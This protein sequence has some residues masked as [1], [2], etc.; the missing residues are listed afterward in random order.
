MTNAPGKQ[1]NTAAKIVLAAIL[2]G[3]VAMLVT[4]GIYRTSNP[5]LTKFVQ[6]RN[7]GSGEAKTDNSAHIADLMGKLKTDPNNVKLIEEIAQ[8]FM[9]D[10]EY[11]QARKF[12]QRG[13]TAKPGNAHL[14]YMLGM[15][16]FKLESYTKAAKAFETSL[17]LEDDP[18]ARYNLGVLLKYYLDK[19]A[20]GKIQ[21]QKILESGAGSDLKAAAQKELDE[22]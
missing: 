19:P 1:P 8:H 3:F 7:A 5:S 21:F 14:F 6:S 13:I 20:E 15:A 4:S 10:G 18:S 12:I 2:L 9:E 16:N 11:S 22:K 17:S